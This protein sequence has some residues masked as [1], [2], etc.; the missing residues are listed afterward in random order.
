MK[1]FNLAITLKLF[2]ARAPDLGEL[3]NAQTVGVIP[4]ET[5]ST[6]SAK[7]FKESISLSDLV[8]CVVAAQ[9]ERC[10]GNTHRLEENGFL[11]TL[12]SGKNMPY[13]REKYV[14]LERYT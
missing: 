7:H 6:L 8:L 3:Q 5:G 12:G 9:A 4:F 1:F 14:Y 11:Y 2:K 13:I 10:T